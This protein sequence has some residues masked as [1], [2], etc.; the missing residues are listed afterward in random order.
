[1]IYCRSPKKT[2]EVLLVLMLLGTFNAAAH[3]DKLPRFEL[4]ISMAVLDLPHY[5]GSAG[6]TSYLL[7]LPYLKYRGERLEIDNGIDG[8]LFISDNLVLSL[9]GNATPPVDGDSPERAGMDE[10][11]AS[12]EIGPSLDIRLLRGKRSSLWLELPLRSAITFESNPQ[13]IGQVFNPRLAW[14]KPYQIKRDWK[15]RLAAGPMYASSQYH[16][17]YYSVDPADA[18]PT[19]PAFKAEAGYSGLRVDFT[20]SKRFDEYWLGGFIRY[21]NLN[22]SVIENSPLVSDT[23]VWMSG[24]ALTWVFMSR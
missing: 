6:S 23:S 24:V 8:F 11:E 15:L 4:G 12:I 13:S 20:Y 7:P 10:L 2:P 21:D 14:D 5:R 3:E 19:R 18:L 22:G 1:M 9:S 17:Y 16:D